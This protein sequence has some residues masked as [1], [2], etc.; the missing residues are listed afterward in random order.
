[1]SFKFEP[2]KIQTDE[3]K[4]P[5]IEDARSDF[6]PFYATTKTLKQAKSEVEKNFAK[7]GAAVTRFQSGKFTVGSQMRH[8]YIV[9]FNWQGLPGQINIAGLPI[10]KYTSKKETQVR[11]QA[12]LNVSQWLQTL[13]TQ[14]VFS[15]GT[16]PLVPYLLTDNGET[17]LE[18]ILKS[19]VL[20]QLEAPEVVDAEIIVENE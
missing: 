20:P 19:G 12:L 16:S 7:L 17:I 2:D 4:A 5:F 18:K 3:I 8:G 6:A 10:R 11:T 9:E 14:Q 15:P 13:I 1:M